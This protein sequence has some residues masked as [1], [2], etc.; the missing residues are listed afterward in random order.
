MGASIN[1]PDLAS[2]SRPSSRLGDDVS[3]MF[4]PFSEVPASFEPVTASTDSGR[5]MSLNEDNDK[6]LQEKKK[7]REE[8]QRL[9][10]E[11]KERNHRK[12][13]EEKIL[14]DKLKQKKGGKKK[15]KKKKKKS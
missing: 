4:D 7:H 15:K 6:Y 11:E 1:I 9:E 13:E 3:G 14:A 5:V 8:K 2:H 12:E 10:A